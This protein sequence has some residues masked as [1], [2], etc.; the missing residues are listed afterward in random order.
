M[1]TNRLADLLAENETIL[2]D[3][4]MGTQLFARGLN[5]GA[6]PET[7]NVEFPD[8]VLD[9]HRQYIAAG[10]RLILT[11]SFGGTTFRLKLHQLQDHS[12]ELNRAAAA[13]GRLAADEVDFPVLVAGSIG[14][15]GEILEPMG[16]MSFTA[17]V[18]SFA[19]QAHGLADGGVDLFWI[20]TM[21]DLNEV[22]AAV[23]GIRSVSDLPICATMT[24]DTK[25]RTMMGVT[26][27]EA[28]R[29][30]E[31]WGVYAIGGNC[32]NGPDEIEA[33]VDTM[34]LTNPESI[35]IAKSNAGI[36]QWVNNALHYDGTPEVMADYARRVR[37]LGARIIGGCCGSTPAHIAAMARALDEAYDPDEP[38]AARGYQVVAA[39]RPDNDREARRRRRRRD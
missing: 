24:F 26:P 14:P 2:I 25:G 27:Q 10:S 5:S 35:L 38:I 20:E 39:E 7:W 33:V 32:G 37:A 4:A 8:R 19:V 28:V 11:N 15:T 3:G 23:E 30:L 22:K 6:P 18:E 17:A 9:V 1:Q 13:I 12:Y 36:P 16:N 29:S 21:S 34:H 31:G